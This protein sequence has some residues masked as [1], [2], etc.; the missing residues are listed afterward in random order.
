M[1]DNHKVIRD[2]TGQEMVEA[3]QEIAEAIRT[4]GFSGSVLAA[5]LNEDNYAAVMKAWFASKG[6]AAMAD[7]TD[8]CEEWY[9]LTR[10]GWSGGVRFQIPASGAAANSDGSKTGDNYG[11]SCTPSTTSVKNQDDYASVPLF[12]PI[13]C[14]VELDANGDPHIKGID[15]ICGS[16]ARTDPAK[17]VCVMQMT[18]WVRFVVDNTV[19]LYG[20]DYT[21][22]PMKD[23]FRPLP[24][25]VSLY[26]NSVRSFV[27]HGKYS[28][29][30]NWSCCSGQKSMIWTVSH[31]SQLTGVQSQWGTRYCGATSADDAFMKLMLYLKYAR[32]DTDRILHGCNN[33]NYEYQPAVAETGVERII[34]TTAQGANLIVG[35]T[36]V[37][38]A[39]KRSASN[40][41]DRCRITQI[42]T[43]SIDGTNY[44][45]IYVDNGGTTFNTTTDMWLSTIAWH[46]GSTDDVLGNDGG[47][48]P[49]SDRYPVKIQ[50]IEYM[51]GF[52]EVMGDVILSYGS[53]DSVNKCI[54]NVCRDATKLSTSVTSDYAAGTGA[55]TGSSAAWQYPKQMR[56]RM[57]LLELIFPYDIGGSTSGG[58]RD[59]FYLLI[60]TSG[61]YEWL[62]FGLLYNGVGTAGLSCGYGGYG[63]GS[64]IWTVGGRLSVT[65]NRGEFQAAA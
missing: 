37:L 43:V 11:M 52:Y 54:P 1:A 36:V 61:V 9:A 4:G 13:D 2:Q 31:N 17:I 3:M 8:L 58:P 6:A 15:G 51:L 41:V 44:S 35:S 40:V 59:G 21:D 65:G 20:W 48:D 56:S 16:F 30:P 42:V 34:L 25:A 38:A 14:N 23:G 29:G 46:T 7:F 53:Q 12:F 57:D 33:Y 45:A 32:L 18:G 50:G 47:I 24:E 19:A 27:V 55:P 10:T 39:S 63:L 5:L 28:F 49:T 26:D 22:A 60:V 62:R 64:A